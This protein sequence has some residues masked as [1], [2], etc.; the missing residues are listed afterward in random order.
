MLSAYV[1]SWMLWVMLNGERF[2]TL[3]FFSASVVDAAVT[4]L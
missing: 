4:T 1:E 2:A 3:V